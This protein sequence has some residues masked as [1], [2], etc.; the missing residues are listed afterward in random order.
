M[1][2]KYYIAVDC[3]GVACAVGEYGQGLGEGEN[4]RF[5]CLQATREANAAAQALFESG[6]EEVI[7][8]D[9]H[10]SGVNLHYD[11]LDARCK[12]LLGSGHKG[13]FIGLDSSFTAVLFIGYHAMA[14][15]Q[16]AVLAHTFSSKAYQSYKLAGKAVGELA[17]DAAWAGALGV[18]VL[19]CA[20]DDR[21]LAEATKLFGP[22]ATV[23]TKKSLSWNSAISKQPAAVCEEIYKTTLEAAMTGPKVQPFLLPSP[24]EVE[25]RYQRPDVA[26]QAHLIDRFG[27]PFGFLDAY[28]RQGMVNRVQD[29]F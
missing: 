21:C 5:A 23:E 19:L 22:I 8:W 12:I 4:Y 2:K 18:P 13:R 10:S 26:A 28:T 11:L 14:G 7:V 16:D 6:A 29:L 27:N 15:T 24:L 9:A 20:S 1:G 25:I 3:E 17:I